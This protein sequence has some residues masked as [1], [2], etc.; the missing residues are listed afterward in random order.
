MNENIFET[1]FFE[2]KAGKLIL[3]I[4]QLSKTKLSL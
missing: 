1:I 2:G 3:T 4:C